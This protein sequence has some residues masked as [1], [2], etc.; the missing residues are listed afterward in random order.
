[1]FT[2]LDAEQ[3]EQTLQQAVYKGKVSETAYNVSL[4]ID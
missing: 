4:E 2:R 1:M 3:N